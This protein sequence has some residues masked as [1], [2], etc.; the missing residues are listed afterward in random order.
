MAKDSKKP[1]V[2]TRR[3]ITPVGMASFPNL[4]VAK[5]IKENDPKEEPK[6]RLTHVYK[7]AEFS[8]PN[9]AAFEQMVSDVNEVCRLEL[10]KTFD[11]EMVAA[12]DAALEEHKDKPLKAHYAAFKCL[13]WFDKQEQIT[14]SCRSPFLLG[15]N[16]D[17]VDDDAIFIRLSSKADRPPEVVNQSKEPLAEAD[18]YGGAN[19]RASYVAY[20][21][22]NLGNRGVTLYMGNVQKC[23]KGIRLGGGPS[24]A[25]EFDEVEPEPAEDVAF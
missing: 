11:D 16:D 17:Y 2:E 12:F 8:A 18:I 4:F 21:Y 7:P 22:N 10:H 15:K 20:P 14:R 1:K 3:G 9:K 6:F 19:V 24:A 13:T 25:D 23:G 5:K